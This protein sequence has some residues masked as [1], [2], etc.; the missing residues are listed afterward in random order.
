M[1][2]CSDPEKA[3]RMKSRKITPRVERPMTMSRRAWAMPLQLKWA[4]ATFSIFCEEV[5]KDLA[6]ESSPIMQCLDRRLHI[7]SEINGNHVSGAQTWQ[8][9]RKVCGKVRADCPLIS[10]LM[11]PHR[12]THTQSHLF[13]Y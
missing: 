6:W 7:I 12:N 3:Q 13:T 2:V 5:W 10:A 8:R 9:C 1:V 11:A 4:D